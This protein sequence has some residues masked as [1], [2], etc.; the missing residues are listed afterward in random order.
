MILTIFHCKGINSK[1]GRILA[2][3]DMLDMFWT[4]RRLAVIFTLFDYNSMDSKIGSVAR[5]FCVAALAAI[6]ALF[7]CG[8][9][10]ERLLEQSELQVLSPAG[11]GIRGLRVA[12]V[13]PRGR[14]GRWVG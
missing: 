12:T 13:R 3:L 4:C 11:R 6:L 5:M 2:V 7:D 9:V 8:E 14:W 10:W 1:F